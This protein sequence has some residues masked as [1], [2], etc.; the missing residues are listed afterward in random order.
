MPNHSVVI[1]C[2]LEAT[3]VEAHIVWNGRPT[4]WDK[5]RFGD[6]QIYAFFSI[7]NGK[8]GPELTSAWAG[9]SDDQRAVFNKVKDAAAK[10]IAMGDEFDL[11]SPFAAVGL[12][13]VGVSDEDKK[14]SG[15]VPRG[16]A[17]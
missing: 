17:R 2:K 6:R 7:Y 14:R 5:I 11:A 9:L 1:Q 8:S 3:I 4:A 10:A 16:A 13:P 15:Q 12:D